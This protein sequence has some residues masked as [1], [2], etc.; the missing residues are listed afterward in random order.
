MFNFKIGFKLVKKKFKSNLYFGCI[1]RRN[2]KSDSIFKNKSIFTFN[3]TRLDTH[4]F[5]QKIN[6]NHISINPI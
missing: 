3:D 5:D 2:V 4:R 6:Y 1:Q